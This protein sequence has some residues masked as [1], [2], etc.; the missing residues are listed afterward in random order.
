MTRT[1]G[2]IT[3]RDLVV[4]LDELFAR[5]MGA[6]VEREV[7]VGDRRVDLVVHYADEHGPL[8]ALVEVKRSTPRTSYR[9]ENSFQQLREYAESY[10]GS[11][12]SGRGRV[13]MMLAIPSTIPRADYLF[14]EE[15]D[16]TVFDAIAMLGMASREDDDL[17]I[18][19][20]EL[21]S[22]Y[23]GESVEDIRHRLL[24][25]VDQLPNL[26]S[27]PS[28]DKS[29][30]AYQGAWR[31][32]LERLF[33]PP[34]EPPEYEHVNGSK[35][36]RRDIIFANY[37]T[38]GFWEFMR[39]QYQA[40]FVVVDAKNYGGLVTKG[41]VLQVANYLSVGSLGLFGIIACRNGING[42]AK[43]VQ[44]E[45]WLLHRKMILVLDHSDL[46][47]MVY[48]KFTEGSADIVLRQKLQDFRLSI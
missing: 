42:T 28:G 19:A 17:A 30:S 12:I 41:A 32:I 43:I 4:F 29:W 21:F 22:S 16:V 10:K 33:V 27:I 26:E 6:L 18:R 20:R 14:G 40:E 13:Q 34:L 9:L 48:T 44:K 45:Q 47:E 3:E 15:E 24:L 31:D 38:S 25:T 39:T 46:R 5:R 11:A 7:T 36:N 23:P 8:T 35:A 2:D 1:L 37:A